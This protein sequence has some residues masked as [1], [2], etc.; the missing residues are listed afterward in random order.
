LALRS[1]VAEQRRRIVCHRAGAYASRTPS[2]FTLLLLIAPD[3]PRS[4]LGQLRP[5]AM[6]QASFVAASILAQPGQMHIGPQNEFAT[7][8]Q[9]L[10][11][12]KNPPSTRR[13][14]HDWHFLISFRVSSWIISI[15]V[16]RPRARAAR[17]RAW[18]CSASAA[19]SRP[20]ES[21]PSGCDRGSASP[22]A[23]P[24]PARSRSGSAAEGPG[25]AAAC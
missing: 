10:M 23:S 3:S 4:F 14:T 20:A 22:H 2:S 5:G 16:A 19:N 18:R 12:V 25:R 7:I 1:P 6:L 13:N 11:P 9:T 15:L 24:T 17:R 8:G 21:D